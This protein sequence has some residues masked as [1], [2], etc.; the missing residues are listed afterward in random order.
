MV[1]DEAV[2]LDHSSL[3]GRVSDAHYLERLAPCREGRV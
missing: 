3:G 1:L 2:V